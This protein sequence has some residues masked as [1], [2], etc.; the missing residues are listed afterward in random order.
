MI[1]EI[2]NAVGFVKDHGLYNNYALIRNH[3][4]YYVTSE[5]VNGV[6]CWNVFFDNDKD[7]MTDWIYS[8]IDLRDCLDY[9]GILY[10]D[11]SEYR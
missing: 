8:S 2:K 5:L 6:L 1:I 11:G 4:G 10:Y 3:N 7:L 9:C